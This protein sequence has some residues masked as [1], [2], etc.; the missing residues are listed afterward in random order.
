MGNCK[1]GARQRDTIEPMKPEIAARFTPAMLGNLAE[2]Y[3]LQPEGLVTLDGFESFIY[4]A[5]RDGK[6]LILRIGHSGR[7]GEP[8]VRGE[9]DWLNYL[10][11][12]GASVAGAAYSTGGNLVETIDDGQG[13]HFIATAFHQAPGVPPWEFGWSPELYIT[14]GKA[15][16][17]MHALTG[18]YIPRDPLGFRPN[19]DHPSIIDIEE[20]LGERDP[21][22]VEK[23]AAYAEQCRAL[24]RQKDSFGL[25]HFDAHGLNFLV[26]A[27]DHIT[28]FDF[29][30]CNYNWFAC[31]IA[32][33]LFY[34]AMWEKDRPAFTRHFLAKFFEGYRQEHRLHPSWLATIPM[35]LKMREIDLY[36][37]ICRD[38]DLANLDDP[39]VVRFMKGRRE[40][41]HSDV[42]YVAM[43]FSELAGCL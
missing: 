18:R 1:S 25:I 36:G 11:A 10:A 9:V 17:R 20:N 4:Q 19:W 12:G 2:R 21:L 37:V 28:F 43:D 38:F 14:Y 7:R 40:S 16:G 22:A 29:D 32:I 33:V 13:E 41:V 30:D 42:P 26:D 35:F 8:F 27:V 23:F 31:D 6:G 39:W 3:G 34:I 5:E 15:L 24:P